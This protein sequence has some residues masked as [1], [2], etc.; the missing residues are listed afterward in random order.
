MSATPVRRAL[1]IAP[2]ADDLKSLIS[3]VSPDVSS[4]QVEVYGQAM[5]LV[6]RE[7]LKLSVDQQRRFAKRRSGVLRDLIIKVIEAPEAEAPAERF[8]L[9]AQGPIET[10]KGSGVGEPLDL[11]EGQRRVAKYALRAEEDAGWAGPTAGPVEVAAKLGVSR[12]TL[13]AW[14]TKR[15]VVGLLDGVRK[16]VFP[17]EQFAGAK[18]LAGI[19]DV[20]AVIP[21]PQAAWMWLKEHSP[22]LDGATPLARLKRG[23]VAD[24]VEAA[25]TLYG[26]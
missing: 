14:Q 16:T 4:A 26:Q 24:V 20:L 5:A 9:A 3:R 23:R 25:R 10:S 15:L 2:A 21:E 13:H 1:A 17:L 7:L 6:S 22:L 12:S 8:K 11:Q 18:P 19:A